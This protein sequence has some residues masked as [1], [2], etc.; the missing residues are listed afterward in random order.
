MN[1]RLNLIQNWPERAEHSQ[2]SAALMA[3]NCGVS[4]RTLERHFLEKFGKCPRCWI[5][6][7]QQQRALEHLSGGFNVNETAAKLGYGH[8]SSF[9]HKFPRLREKAM[10]TV[11]SQLAQSNMSQTPN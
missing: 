11:E 5:G 10:Q 7:M 8:T 2:W 3:Q 6:Q 9:C 1:T 4:L